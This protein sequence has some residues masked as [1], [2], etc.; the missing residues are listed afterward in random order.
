MN[1]WTVVALGVC[2]CASCAGHVRNATADATPGDVP[3]ASAPDAAADS[4][5]QDCAVPQL[6]LM[7]A[8]N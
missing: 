6:H 5:V 3:E 7:V 2:F 4:K 8:E 1:N